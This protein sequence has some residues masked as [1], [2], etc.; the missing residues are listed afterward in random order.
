MMLGMNAADALTHIR[1]HRPMAG[2]EAG[3]QRKFIE[4][5]AI[6]LGD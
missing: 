3:T 6:H 4:D 5:L 2:P 1:E